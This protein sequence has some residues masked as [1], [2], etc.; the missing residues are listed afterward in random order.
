MRTPSCDPSKPLIDLG[1]GTA[2]TLDYNVPQQS[3]FSAL[4]RIRLDVPDGWFLDEW[5][6]EPE[7]HWWQL[8]PEKK[9]HTFEILEREI[10]TLHPRVRVDAGS[11]GRGKAASPDAGGRVTTA[12]AASAATA[13]AAG[14]SGGS[15][16]RETELVVDGYR[17]IPLDTLGGA[18]TL[19]Y[20]PQPEEPLPRLYLVEEYRVCSYLADYG[21]G[22]TLNTFS[23]L[24]GEKTKISIRTYRDSEESRTASENILDSFSQESADELEELVQSEAGV[25][26]GSSSSQTNTTSGD[27]GIGVGVSLFGL[28]SADVGGSIESSGTKSA[29]TSE[30]E[31]LDTLD[32]SLSK[33]IEQSSYS[34]EIEI[35]STTSE[36]VSEGEE[37]TIV[38]ELANLNHSRVLNFVFRQLLQEYITVSYLASV[39]VAFS[40]GYPESI[41]SMELS[42]LDE[43]LPKFIKADRVEEVKARILAPYCTVFNYKQE[44]KAFIR[45]IEQ[46]HG[47][48]DFPGHQGRRSFYTKDPDLVDEV[49]GIEVAGVIKRVQRNVLRT[50]A[51]IVEALLGQGEALDCYNQELQAA[52]VDRSQLANAVTRSALD[53]VDSIEPPA[54]KVEAYA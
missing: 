18:T 36:T 16:K 24:P 25:S 6:K 3:C 31:Y 29:E 21:A 43:M 34:R 27:A 4:G 48:C 54:A 8:T 2:P 15:L 44:P 30:E 23:L 53:I 42:S 10:P 46:R 45:K 47:D 51:V 33:H 1:E 7:T 35:N 40:N 39:R 26:Y 22:K 28:V 9:E 19:Q 14:I 52:A 49:E 32:R 50:P 20:I 13:P 11:L 5:R 37:E 38:R 17:P 41:E 12:A